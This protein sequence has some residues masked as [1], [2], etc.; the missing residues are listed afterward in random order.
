MRAA[1]GWLLQGILAFVVC[2]TLLA[3]IQ[4]A[5]PDL[6]DVDGYYH[7]KTAALIRDHGLPLHFP[8]LKFT[9]LDEA[10]Y[11][12]HHLLQHLLQIPFTYLGDLR[13]GAKWSAVCFAAFAFVTFACILRRYELRF[14]LFWVFVLFASSPAFLFR[15]SM[16]RGQSLSLGLQLIAFH[17][18]LQRRP[19]ALAIVAAI[20]VWTYNGFLILLPLTLCGV[21]A[22]WVVTRRIE[23][24][25]LVGV[26]SGIIAGLVVHPYFPRDVF[27]L[28]NHIAPKLLTNNY[29]TSVGT[30]WYPYS[31]WLLLLNAPLALAAYIG[32]LFLTNR[33]EWLQDAPRLFWFLVSTLYLVLLLKSRRFVEYFP[34]SAVLFLAF[35]VRGWAR[36]I[37]VSSFFDNK[38]R[39]LATMAGSVLLVAVFC[40]AITQVR[41]E[42]A[43]SPATSTYQGGAEWLATHTPEGSSIFHTDWDDFPMLFYFNTHNTYLVGLDPDFMRL[44]N[45]KLF[46]SWE[47]ITRGAVGAPEDAILQDFGCEYVFTDNLHSGFLAIADHSPRMQKVYEDIDVTIYRVLANTLFLDLPPGHGNEPRK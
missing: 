15:M 39:F 35:T 45:P 13:L 41:Q 34:P 44:K 5:S 37:P 32:A 3:S 21:V 36:D 25:L 1:R 16:P 4:F 26:V 30:E 33:E 10:G 29:T 22:H 8:W 40:S 24:L 2:G 19:V 31:S 47:A 6:V 18:L 7:I 9:L 14:P 27:F 17:F 11:T 46:R 43:N 23:Y 38:T 42:I 12:D 28:W 20:F